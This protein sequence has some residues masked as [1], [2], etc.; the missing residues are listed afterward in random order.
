MAGIGTENLVGLNTLVFSSP[1]FLFRYLPVF[2][3][4]FFLCPQKKRTGF[5]F[6][7]SL[8]LY[9]LA[10]PDYAFLLLGMC[11]MNYL[12]GLSLKK[13]TAQEADA[14]KE[15]RRRKGLLFLAVA[16]NLSLL[17]YFKL[18][19]VF[20]R[21]FLLPLG[22]SFYTFK[23]VS[24]LIDVYRTQVDA[25][26]SFFAFGAYLCLFPQVVSGPIMRFSEAADGLRSRYNF[27]E[28][29][30][31]GL[32]W[33]VAGLAAK[34]LIA[35]RLAILWND[36]QTIGLESIS[37][38]LAWLGA[39]GYSLQ[40][41]F[42]FAGYSMMAAGMGEMIGLPFLKN[43]DFPYASRS[44]S[45]FYR[46]WHMTLG[47]WFRDYVYIPLGGNRRGKKRT[48][49]NLLLVWLLTGF[50]HGNG[51]HF[52]LWGLL[53]G[54]LVVLEKLWLGGILK[55]H[56][57]LAHLYVLLVIPLT[58]MVFALPSL[59]Q[60]G[61]YFCRLFPFWGKGIA[62]NPMDFA[63]ELRMFAP[64]FCAAALF[65]IPAAGRWFSRHKK[66]LPVVIALTVV[67]WVCVYQMVNMTEN[68][69]LYANF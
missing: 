64:T 28:R 49:C 63:K 50:W 47:S 66:D 61:V 58:W 23:S 4:L 2:L 51:L 43:F 40:L 38:P 18:S 8:F 33:M 62:V 29:V 32:K 48:V 41:Y 14:Q 26:R 46:R 52:V 17:V 21:S 24:Y 54:L 36:I 16:C 57:L 67:F 39:F 7:G 42:D 37:T 5:L 69:F 59:S 10:Q 56:P 30:E 25:E 53:L 31:D 34:I 20:D 22:I 11:G 6:F 27:W 1:E 12:F 65:C 44:V 55:K 13:R 60:I 15:E 19:N 68:P 45:E 3:L 35:D 9:A